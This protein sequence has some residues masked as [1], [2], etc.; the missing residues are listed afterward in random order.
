[1]KNRITGID[2][3][4]IFIM[5]IL[6]RATGLIEISPGEDAKPEEIKMKIQPGEH[7]Y[8]KSKQRH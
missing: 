2:L 4:V 8:F 1:M 7:L 3:E 5:K 6:N